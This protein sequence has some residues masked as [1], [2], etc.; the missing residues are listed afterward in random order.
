M[1]N[2]KFYSNKG[3]KLHNQGM[4]LEANHCYNLAI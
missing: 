4:S 3:Y 1:L 2:A